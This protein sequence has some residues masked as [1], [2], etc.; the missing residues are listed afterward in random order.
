MQSSA[1]ILAG[2]FAAPAL[3]LTVID[4]L[5]I[6]RL[7]SNHADL[8]ESLGR[9][10]MGSLSVYRFVI[11]RRYAKSPDRIFVASGT[12]LRW[13]LILWTVY[14]LTLLAAVVLAPHV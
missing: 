8:W 9:P 12:L 4:H 10:G 11:A 7:R 1:L 6:R 5:F 13:G 2:F 3:A 14:V